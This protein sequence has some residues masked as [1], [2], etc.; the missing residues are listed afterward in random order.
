[1]VQ[2]VAVFHPGTQHSWQTAL[3]LQRLGRLQFYATSIFYQKDRWPY[4]IER[5]LPSKARRYLANEFR[6]FSFPPLDSSLV[7][8]SGAMEWCERIAARTGYRSFAKRLDA[9]GNRQ[10]AASL[11]RDI[12]SADPFALWGYSSS[13]LDAFRAAK[14]RGRACILDRTIGDWRVYNK[15]M[16]E[17][18]DRY[19]TFFPNDNFSVSNEQIERDDEEYSL[20]DVI[21]TGSPFAASTVTQCAA[22]PAARSRV[23]VLNYCYDEELFGN[24]GAPLLRDVNGPVRFLFMGQAGV[25]KG[26][27]LILEVFNR[28]PVSAASLTIVGD[29]QVPPR[30]FARYSDRVEYRPTV[31]RAD[32][33]EFMANSDVLLFPSY[34][35]G[36]GLVLY[37]ALASNIAL[38][39]SKNAALAVTPETG[40]LLPELSE[41]ALY[42]AVMTAIEDRTKLNC[43]RANAQNEAKKYSFARY[44]ENISYVLDEL[45]S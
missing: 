12:K 3:A 15:S 16:A 45:M 10:F 2:N 44:Q 43:W 17:I 25:R 30:V 27:H 34:F 1:M 8:T 21:L 41:E 18:Y 23:R 7:R 32:V 20:A 24:I 33:P 9:I 28:I 37:E 29:L 38:I 4:R 13:S 39:Q 22:D 40:I 14:E 11:K 19:S 5:Y 35:E 6:R 42:A 36:A 31:A 26:I